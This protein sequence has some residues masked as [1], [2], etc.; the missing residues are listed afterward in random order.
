MPGYRFKIS[1]VLWGGNKK[2]FLCSQVYQQCFSLP[3]PLLDIVTWYIIP[4]LIWMQEV[5]CS[6]LLPSFYKVTSR[7]NSLD[8]IRYKAQ[9]TCYINF[10]FSCCIV[11][12]CAPCYSRHRTY[13]FLI[14]MDE[15][16][17]SHGKWS[18]RVIH[19]TCGMVPKIKLHLAHN[20]ILSEPWVQGRVVTATR[21]DPSPSQPHHSGL[22]L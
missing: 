11:P 6:F 5:G 2:R 19:G 4:F 16:I 18:R 8:K 10:S 22:G 3:R 20:F 14:L 17:L 7:H 13:Q 21:T 15:R 12:W 9:R 1:S